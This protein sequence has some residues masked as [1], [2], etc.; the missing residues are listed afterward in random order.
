MTFPNF[1]YFSPDTIEEACELLHDNKESAIMAGGT[2]MLIKLQG[3]C[4][5]SKTIINLKKIQGLDNISFDKC[6]LYIGAT[7]LLSTVAS[8]KTIIYKFPSIA[9]SAKETAT[10]Q[11]R[12]MGTV[13]G[14]V[15]NAAPSADNT[16][17][18]MALGAILKIESNSHK[19]DLPIRSLFRGPGI[20]TLER[21]EIVTSI[22]VPFMQKYSGDSYQHISERSK[23]DIPAA[24]VGLTLVMNKQ[25]CKQINVFLGAVGPTP[26]HATKTEK[27]VSG[28][29]LTK[30]L[31]DKAAYQAS[32][33]AKPITD[34]RASAEYR[35]DMISVLFK[36]AFLEAKSRCDLS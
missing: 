7:A 31:I 35:R 34:V 36:K 23:V 3:G 6:G 13:V 16:P 1:K 20:N 18:L 28:N 32:M 4:V 22:F 24:S 19:R 30:E 8:N 17:T 12:N 11:I 27:L 29:K 2:D 5:K 33:E 26:I 14:N 9:Y 10:V 15:C 25:T 21:D